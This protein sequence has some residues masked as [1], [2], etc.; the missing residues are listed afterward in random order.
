VFAYQ[1]KIRRQFPYHY[2][3]AALARRW[4][5]FSFGPLGGNPHRDENSIHHSAIVA[6]CLLRHQRTNDK[7][8]HQYK[9]ANPQK[10]YE[11]HIGVPS[12]I[13]ASGRFSRVV[14]V[15]NNKSSGPGHRVG[16]FGAAV[17]CL[18]GGWKLA[19]PILFAMTR[20]SGHQVF[21][22]YQMISMKSPNSY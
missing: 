17:F 1:G 3:I 14:I 13:P 2:R 20:T 21:I 7:L 4:P 10:N 12:G 16:L 6:C 5:W 22:F 9:D 11:L 15:A 18:C 8:T 19:M